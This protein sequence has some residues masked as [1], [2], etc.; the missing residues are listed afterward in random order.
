MQKLAEICIRRPVFAAMLV[1]AL[2]VVGAAELLPARRRS[3]PVGRP[4]HRQ[5][6]HDAARRLAGRGGDARSRSRSRRRSTPSRA[7]TSCARSRASGTLDRHRHLQPRPRHRRRRRRTCATAS[8]TVVRDLPR[9]RRPA[10]RHQVRQRLDA[11]ASRIALSGDRPLRELT[12]LADKIVKVQLERSDGVGEVRDRR[13]PRARDQRLGRRRPPRRLPASD[14]RRA[15]RHRAPERRRARRQ[16]HRPAARADAAHAWAASPTRAAFDD[17]VVATVNGAPDPRPRHRPRRGRHQGAALAGAA[18]RRADGHRSRCAG[19]RARTPSRSS[20]RSRRTWPRVAA[21]LPA[22]VQARGHPRPVALHL[23]GAARDQPPPRPRAAS[24][25]AW[26][27]SLFMRSWRSTIIAGVAIPASV[28]STFG[29][30]WALDFTLNSVTMLALVLMVG[31]VID[32]AIVV[33]ENIFRFVEEKRMTPFEAAREAT[34]RDRAGGAGD[35]ASPGGDLRAGVV[36]VERSR[37]ASST[38]SASRRRS[39]SWSACW[40]RSR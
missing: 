18:Q 15:R 38:S 31:I 36:H 32:D 40:C 19:S 2:V 23:R 27:C 4:A 29:M 6:A 17:L 8:P 26:W 22:D 16:R 35:H 33:L 39:R 28:I 3:L 37:G 25:P 7:S 14:H 11:G 20:R 21:Q 13:R 10:G 30:M 5:R 1:L 24:W 34:A 9:R 12:E